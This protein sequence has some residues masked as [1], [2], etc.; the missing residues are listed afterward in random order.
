M[1]IAFTSANI[2]KINEN[3]NSTTINLGKVENHLKFI[4]NI[5]EEE[6]NL[7]ILKI[8]IAQ[9]YKN[10]PLIEYEVFY[11]LNNGKI[12]ILNLSSCEGMDIEISIPIKINDTVDKY[13][14]KSNY[15]NKR[16]QRIILI[17]L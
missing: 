14:P 12:E 11:P 15:Y 10:Y 9:K 7:Y 5:S 2:Q 1:T 8:D 3:S 6:V 13:N 4:Y 16:L 17:S